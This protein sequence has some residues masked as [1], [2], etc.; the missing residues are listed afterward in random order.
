MHDCIRKKGTGDRALLPDAHRVE[1][2]QRGNIPNLIC[3]VGRE[4]E[5]VLAAKGICQ[6]SSVGAAYAGH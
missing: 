6:L 4:K 3:S 2:A 1:G 5:V